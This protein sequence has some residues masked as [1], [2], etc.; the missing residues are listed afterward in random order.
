[1]LLPLAAEE[2]ALLNAMLAVASAHRSKWQQLEDK[3]S[4]KFLRKTLVRLQEI[5]GSR[6]DAVKETTLATI[7]CLVSYEVCEMNGHGFKLKLIIRI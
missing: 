3:E 7:L 2:P 4:Q 6:E 1:M 5:M